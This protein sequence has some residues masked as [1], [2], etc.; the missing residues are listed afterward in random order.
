MTTHPAPPDSELVAL[1]PCPFCGGEPALHDI[2]NSHTKSRSTAI[3]CTGCHFT[4]KVGAIVQSLDWTRAKA[5]EAWNTRA[6]TLQSRLDAVVGLADEWERRVMYD[7]PDQGSQESDDGYD[8]GL[9][10]C[11]NELRAA[12]GCATTGEGGQ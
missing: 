1:L 5:I 4:K 10:T 3:W 2:G 9:T 11:A 8:D 12:L 6:D 7:H